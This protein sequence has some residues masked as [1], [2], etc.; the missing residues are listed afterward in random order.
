M[1][2]SAGDRNLGSSARI[3]DKKQRRWVDG[4][5]CYTRKDMARF[6]GAV[7]A[8]RRGAIGAGVALH[9]QYLFSED[10]YK[11]RSWSGNFPG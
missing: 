4:R 10:L 2:T 5:N 8:R 6:G 7:E 1:S 3:G 9:H 11:G